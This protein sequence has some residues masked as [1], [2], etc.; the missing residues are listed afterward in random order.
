MPDDSGGSEAAKLRALEPREASGA[1]SQEVARDTEHRR[2]EKSGGSWQDRAGTKN[3][4]DP[5]R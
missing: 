3:D 2:K 1:P 5:E 4:R